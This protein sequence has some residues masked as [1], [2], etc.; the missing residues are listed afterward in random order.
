MNRMIAFLRGR[1]TVRVES[2]FPER[3][4]NLCGANRISFDDLRW[5][6]VTAFSFTLSRS[7]Y[8][9]LRRCAGKLD[10]S[11]TV[12]RR[13]G[14]PF[15]LA[16]VRRRYAL[17]GGAAAFFLLLAVNSC[18]IWDFEV[19]GND[20]VPTEKILRVLDECGLS[21]GSFGLLLAP[22]ELCN[23]ALPK[24][25]ELCWLTVNVRGCRACV[26]VEERVPKPTIY[27]EK[28][29]CNTVARR[30][31]LVTK[32]LPFDGEAKVLPGMTVLPGQLLISGVVETKG[33][34]N[35]SV[36]ARVYAGTGEVWGRTWHEITARVPLLY[37]QRTAEGTKK[38]RF[39][40]IVGKNRLQFSAKG[41]SNIGVGY[42][43]ITKKTQCELFGLALPLTW[44]HETLLAVE[45]A[46]ARRTRAEAEELGRAL[47][48]RE[49]TAR[50]G[51]T[52]SVTAKR[53]SS[54][55]QG[56]WLIVTLSAECLE[57]IGESA[58]LLLE[59]DR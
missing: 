36:S 44:E 27:S 32:V 19:T 29:T 25:P 18:F 58:A 45:T 26:Q 9:A 49:L 14:A 37:E 20:T 16:R 4:L 30:A 21:W 42:D 38:H 55:V 47:L 56:D 39:A 28:Q 59:K 54:A 10:A 40:L 2:A 7:G 41:S 34:E 24:L 50:L 11:F 43:K 31:A 53:F 46:P 35:P 23:R 52:G 6:S 5:H 17:L 8:R 51:E 22:Q 1:V 13:S 15:L 33:T 12:E 48:E 3:V 57:Q